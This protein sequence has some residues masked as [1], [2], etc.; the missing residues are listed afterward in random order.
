MIL[1]WVVTILH[2]LL[3]AVMIFGV[4]YS[5]TPISQGAVL[6]VLMLMFIGIRTFKTCVLHGPEECENKPTIADFGAAVL[7]EDYKRMPK[8]DHEQSV[9]GTL[10]FMQLFKIY[11]ES[12]YPIETLF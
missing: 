7:I 8:Y 2:A 4:I 9:V 1:E 3:C 11:C 10:L 6:V 12:I 5:K